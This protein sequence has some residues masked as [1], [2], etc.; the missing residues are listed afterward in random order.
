MK[1]LLIFRADNEREDTLQAL[2]PLTQWGIQPVFIPLTQVVFSAPLPEA[3]L[4]CPTAC[5]T[6]RNGIRMLH[7]SGFSPEKKLFVVGDASADLARK[8]GFHTITISPNGQASG[9]VSLLKKQHHTLPQPLL[10]VRGQEIK[11]DITSQ[12]RDVHIYVKEY[13]GY[14]IHPIPA[15]KA[16]LNQTLRNPFW[17]ICVLS[18]SIART[19][20]RF[21]DE[22]RS[23]SSFSSSPDSLSDVLEGVPF[24]SLSADI[25]HTLRTQENL[26]IIDVLRP[27]LSTLVDTI[28]H[29]VSRK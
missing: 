23:L 11:Q 1:R 6:S 20:T 28:V 12:L 10:Y 29:Y 26:H 14:A 18:Q 22:K 15:Q 9:L 2:A 8:L 7:Q 24:F 25:T 19:L 5:A 21:M 13:I 27:N 4:R 16:C 17:G 3:M